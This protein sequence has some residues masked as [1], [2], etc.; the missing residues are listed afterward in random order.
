V[1]AEN[2]GGVVTDYIYA[3]GRPI[4]VVQ[5]SATIAANQVNYV[6]ADRLGTP[7]LL[8]SSSGGTVWNTS[9]QP[10]GT[11]GTVTASVIQNLRFPGQIVDGEMSLPS[12]RVAHRRTGFGLSSGCG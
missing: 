8:T 5:P 7:Q 3:D 1:I 6:T 4:A 12:E 9:Y 10:F 11:T 2:D